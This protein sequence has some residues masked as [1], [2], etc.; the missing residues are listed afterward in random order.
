MRSL[1]KAKKTLALLAALA[2]A[3]APRAAQAHC[4]TLDGPVV[5]DARLALG[6]GEVTPVLKWVGPADE[7]AV[8]AA[9]VRTLAVRG[10]GAEARGLTDGYFFETLVR[11]HRAGEGEPFEGLKPAGTAVEPGLAEADR[12][13]AEG[14]ADALGKAVGD[15]A[16][17][18]V[19]ARFGRVRN[20]RAHA[21]ESV[22][23]GRA[24]VDAYV[25]YIHYVARMFADTEGHASRHGHEAHESGAGHPGGN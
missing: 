2:A 5:T 21:D 14:S 4:D 23:A 1:P 16:A 24:W 25:E 12:A 6:K 15:A 20:A 9:F 3:V 13:L 22:T 7:G 11:L 19:R 10:L 17:A 18:G 8:R